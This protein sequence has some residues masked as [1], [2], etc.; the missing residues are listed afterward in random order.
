M[1][2]FPLTPGTFAHDGSGKYNQKLAFRRIF[3]KE[4]M[5]NAAA[6]RGNK[7]EK[8]PKNRGFH[9]HLRVRISEI[10]VLQ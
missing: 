9:V 10:T 7:N 1:N 4:K 2:L 6:D 3:L 8:S 5:K